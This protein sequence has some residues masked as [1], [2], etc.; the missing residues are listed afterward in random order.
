MKTRLKWGDINALNA[1]I[2]EYF[3]NEPIPTIAGLCLH[4]GVSSEFWK[5]YIS[6]KWQ[7]KRKSDE[8]IERIRNMNA[9]ITENEGFVKIEFLSPT[10][11]VIDSK[12]KQI[13]ESETDS[14]K[15]Q[16]SEILRKTQLRIEDFTMKQVFAAKN[17]AGAIFY[18]KA[19]LG[20]RENAPENVAT[21]QL[22]SK[23][24]INI[25]PLP[26]QSQLQSGKIDVKTN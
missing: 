2:D 7:T 17:P 14:L 3:D 12:N 10:T 18:A 6:D 11:T 16:I 22:P 20:Y 25:M 24:T 9:T 8:E 15:R 5:Y 13:V 26:D 21:N 23:I 4:L 19:A 1:K